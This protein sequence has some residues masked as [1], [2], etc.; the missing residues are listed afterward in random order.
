MPSMKKDN[1]LKK[2]IRGGLMLGL[3]ILLGSLVH[4]MIHFSS[5]MDPSSKLIVGQTVVG[6]LALLGTG[7]TFYFSRQSQSNGEE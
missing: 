7:C 3:M 6:V 4:M 2:S 1:G 5:E